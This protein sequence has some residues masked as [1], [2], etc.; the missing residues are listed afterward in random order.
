MKITDNGMV[1]LYQKHSESFHLT[2]MN[3]M[4]L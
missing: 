1:C 2:V 3:V 4:S